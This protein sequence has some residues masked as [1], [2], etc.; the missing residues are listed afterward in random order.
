MTVSR[1]LAETTSAELT[2]WMAFYQLEPFGPERGD[3]QAGIV[4]ATVANVNRDAKKQKKPYSAQDFMPKF[5]GGGGG[6]GAEDAGAVAA[7][8]GD[9]GGGV[10]RTGSQGE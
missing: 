4:A 3:L 8:V 2:E 9:G 5:K 10:W 1:L 7:E 6:E